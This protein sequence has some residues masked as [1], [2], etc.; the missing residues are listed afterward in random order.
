MP[1]PTLS[2]E[3]GGGAS[4]SWED[5]PGEAAAE[6]GEAFT[7]GIS[8][9]IIDPIESAMGI[10]PFNLPDKIKGV[11]GLVPPAAEAAGKAVL[12]F[13]ADPK[14]ALQPTYEAAQRFAASTPGHQAAVVAG[15]IPAVVSQTVAPELKA[16]EAVGKAAAPAVRA[17]R[18]AL[19]LE[20]AAAE[21]AKMRGALPQLA[22]RYPATVPGVELTDPK[23]GKRYIGK[24]NS[25]EGEALLEA[26]R[27]AQKEI[28]AGRYDP[29]FDIQKRRD[30]DPKNY[31]LVADTLKNGRPKT[32]AKIQEWRGKVQTDDARK[33]LQEAF[34]HGIASGY[35]DAWY[36]MGQLEEEFVKE[37]GPEAGRKAFRERF[38]EAMAA[39]TGGAD[40]TS[41]LI[42]AH[43]GN[44]KKV[45]GEP[46]PKAAHEMPAPIG[47]RYVTGN[48]EMYGKTV[49][50]GKGFYE[51]EPMKKGGTKEIIQPKR[52]NFAADFMGH[53]GPVPIDE[54][55]TGLITPGL[56]APPGD[57]YFAYEELVHE[58]A[59][60]NGV[61]PRDFQDVAWG[62]KKAMETGGKYEGKPMIQIV[63][64]AIERT[65]RITGM[66]PSEVVRRGLV[67]AEIPLYGAAGAAVGAGAM[68]GKRAEPGS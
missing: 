30:A 38:A 8:R 43:Y 34:D 28:D 7:T 47:G 9:D 24:V 4:G 42:M 12:R 49:G 53:T 21:S 33:R 58:M 29:Y 36:K 37:L 67:R 17:G 18:K 32:E 22:E 26:R 40:P 59:A 46:I 15:A 19:T 50:Q 60:R 16:V 5:R 56:A 6:A 52:H 65:S 20:E 61:D 14:R 2:S 68:G 66:K 1:A 10:N 41:N 63:N 27:A 48:L 25:P 39:T 51:T 11:L 54:Q 35:H 57:S 31:P 64:E 3:W 62:G 23:T 55:M 13:A 44:F 45:R